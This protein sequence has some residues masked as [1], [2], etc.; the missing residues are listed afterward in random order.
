MN[1]LFVGYKP[2]YMTSNRFLTSFK[3]KL[4][5]KNCGFSGT[6]D[7]FAKGCLIIAFGQY[8]KLFRFLKKSQ[9]T[10]KATIW[11][12]TQ[13]T[14]L[15]IENIFEITESEKIEPNLLKYEIENLKGSHFYTP[16]KFS[17]KWIDGKRAYHLA[18]AGVEFEQKK[19]QME[20]FKTRLISYRHPFISFEATVSEGAYIRSLAQILLEKL[21][22]LGTLSYLE[23]VSEGDFIFENEKN[24]NPLKYLSIDENFSDLPKSHFENGKKL[25]I[26]D[27]AIQKIGIYFIKFDTHFS[28]I[29]IGSEK[30]KYLLNWILLDGN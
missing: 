14:S 5:D 18:R 27:L 24:L 29:E 6:L 11:L 13:S 4:N 9:K 25:K 2:A 15:D 19:V 28:I 10:Y 20:V 7:P 26:E 3:K 8:T 12:G 16:P 30:V 21:Q 1:K 17:A 23:R 22:R